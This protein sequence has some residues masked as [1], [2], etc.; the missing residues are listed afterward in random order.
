MSDVNLLT[1]VNPL[2]ELLRPHVE[3][4][5]AAVMKGDKQAAQ[6]I[7]LYQMHIA[8]PRDPGASALCK[9]AFDAWRSKRPQAVSH[10]EI[11]A[12]QSV[13]IRKLCDE[14]RDLKEEVEMLRR[15]AS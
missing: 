9:A 1:D 7:T 10:A 13:E 6:I 5:E 4:I 12:R 3:A 14:I 15:R 11:A 8:C 2:T